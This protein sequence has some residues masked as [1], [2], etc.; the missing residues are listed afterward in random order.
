L[1]ST[2]WKVVLCSYILLSK[3]I[4]KLIKLKK[5]K[6]NNRKNR[7][8]PKSGKKIEPNPKKTE[9]SRKN[10]AKPVRTGFC[11]KK[12]N[13]NRSVWISFG[14]VLVFFFKFGLIIF[15]D[16]NRT[17]PKIITLLNISRCK[18]NK[19]VKILTYSTFL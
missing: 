9:P 7:T 18:K 3:K 5:Q 6:K 4:K 10:R 11:S 13:R 1:P 8:E 19:K 2:L 16:K 17:K 15:F 14:S 12:P